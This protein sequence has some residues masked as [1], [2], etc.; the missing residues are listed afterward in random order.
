MFDYY[1]YYYYLFY[2]FGPI[3]DTPQNL[4]QKMS[5]HFFFEIFSISHLSSITIIL[6]Y[7]DTHNILTSIQTIIYIYIYI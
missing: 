4:E 3:T 6:K 7:S 2:Y 5:T 1:Y